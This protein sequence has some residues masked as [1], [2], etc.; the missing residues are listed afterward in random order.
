MMRRSPGSCNLVDLG[1]SLRFLR[2]LGVE[3]IYSIDSLTQLRDCHSETVGNE[4]T[5]QDSKSSR[6]YLEHQGKRARAPK[7]FIV[8][9]VL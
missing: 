5:F 2:N 7:I 6:R 8:E 1:R 3:G 9:R 4:D